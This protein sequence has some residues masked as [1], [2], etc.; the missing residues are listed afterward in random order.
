[1]KLL[2]C[3]CFDVGFNLNCVN[4]ERNWHKRIVYL[5]NVIFLLLFSPVLFDLVLTSNTKNFRKKM[6]VVNI[7]DA[8]LNTVTREINYTGAVSL[9]NSN[10]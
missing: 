9:I 3:W 1:M 10:A 7:D 5:S 8:T 4:I 2:F 6:F